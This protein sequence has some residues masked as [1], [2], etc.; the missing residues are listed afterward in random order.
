MI[1]V[2]W[3]YAVASYLKIFCLTVGSIVSILIVSRFKDIAHFAA[4]SANW[5]KTALFTSVQIPF[6]LPM[7]IPISA[8]FASFLLVQ[9]MSRSHELAALRSAGFSLSQILTPL[10][11]VGG[12][13]TLA[14]FFLCAKITP[15]CQLE[16]LKIL[17]QEASPNPL[18]LLQRRKLMKLKNTYVQLKEKEDKIVDLVLI[19]HTGNHPRLELI[20]SDLLRLEGEQFIGEHTAIVSHPSSEGFDFDPLLIENLASLSMQAPLLS[21]FLTKRSHKPTIRAL[22]FR[23][24]LQASQKSGKTGRVALVELLRRCSL[25]LAVLTFTFLGSAFGM[26]SGRKQSKRGSL[27]ALFL[28]LLLLSSYFLGKGL[29]FHATVSFLA[30]LLPHALSWVCSIWRLRSVSRGLEQ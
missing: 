6:I 22:D 12:F 10:L 23:M 4:L 30:F 29:R 18:V 17:H 5:S 14:N 25:S 24:L 15:I 20:T 7:A 13:L 9:K 27:Y 2:F 8:L 3:R 1:P 26:E 19:A 21:E 16:S 28:A 11:F